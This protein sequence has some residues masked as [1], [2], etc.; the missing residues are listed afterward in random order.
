V[1]LRQIG[2]APATGIEL[3]RLDA[4]RAVQRF[5]E[6]LSLSYPENPFGLSLVNLA[7]TMSQQNTYTL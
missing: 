4:P 3:D 5:C 2:I 7:I 1:K 6:N